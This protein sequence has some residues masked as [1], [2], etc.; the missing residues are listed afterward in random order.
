M[1]TLTQEQLGALLR[2][3]EF[4]ESVRLGI[5][6]RRSPSVFSEGLSAKRTSGDRR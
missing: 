6:Y 3:G 1:N 2:E 4:P 5:T